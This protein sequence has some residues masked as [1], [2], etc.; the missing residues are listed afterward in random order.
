MS[1]MASLKNFFNSCLLWFAYLRCGPDV[2]V[3]VPPGVQK[4]VGGSMRN[5]MQRPIFVQEHCIDS[6]LR[7]GIAVQNYG[8]GFVLGEDV[9]ARIEHRNGNVGRTAK[10]ASKN[11]R[12]LNTRTNKI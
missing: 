10:V 4:V 2:G 7:I 1:K 6:V 8:V 3:W 12:I 5:D 11:K 9:L